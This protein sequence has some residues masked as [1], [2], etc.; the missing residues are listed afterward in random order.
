[1]SGARVRAGL[2]SAPLALV[3][4]EALAL[5]NLAVADS[6]SCAL[7]VVVGATLLVRGVNPSELERAE[8]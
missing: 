7:G 4:A 1:M 2:A 8:A 3:S 5:S 6:L